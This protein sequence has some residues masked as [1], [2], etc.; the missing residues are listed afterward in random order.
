MKLW[1]RD[2]ARQTA[3][4][5]APAAVTATAVSADG[6]TAAVATADN[7]IRLVNLA[8]GKVVRELK[9]HT[10]AVSGVAFYP[11]PTETSRLAA[12]EAAADVALAAA[13]TK[14]AVADQAVKDFDPKALKLEG[15][16]I[17]AEKKKRTDAAA[18]AVKATD[19]AKTALGAAKMARAAFAKQVAESSQLVSGSQDK[20]V[21]VWKLADGSVVRQ[22][23]TPAPVNDVAFTKGRCPIGVG[24]CRQPVA[25]LDD[26][27]AEAGREEGRRQEGQEGQEG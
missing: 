7:I 9:G 5:A 12:A 21:R 23:A 24:S 8:D 20:S 1:K 2:A 11:H 17:A 22:V 14:Q 25:G 27:R 6:K 3:K 10:A 18:A 26:G 13:V 16:A 4:L 19:T 15:D